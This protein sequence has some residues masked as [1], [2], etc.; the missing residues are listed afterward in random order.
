MLNNQLC[1]FGDSIYCGVTFDETFGRYTLCRNTFDKKLRSFG[2]TVR[3]NAR[4]GCTTDIALN[5]LDEAHVLPGAVC[6]I[7]FGG[8]DSD[9]EWEK[10]AADPDH[11]H[12]GKVSL[13]QFKENIRELILFAREKQMQPVVCTPLPVAAE[14][15]FETFSKGLDRSALMR[16][17]HN[18]EYIYRWQERYALGAQQVACSMNCE[19]FDLRSIFLYQRDFSAL[20]CR[21]GIHPSAGGYTL[22]TQAFCSFWGVE[23][24]SDTQSQRVFHPFF[25]PASA[26]SF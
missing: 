18:T 23:S 20:M 16:Y 24:V 26:F 11:Y 19:V 22:M 4:P 9:L 2:V 8:N 15:Y 25:N 7:S 6:L 12:E 5:H 1:I 13:A 3:N 10:V 21:D 17:L 14:R